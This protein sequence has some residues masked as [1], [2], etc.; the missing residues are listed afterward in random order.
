MVE[1][2]I[3]SQ[4]GPARGACRP[5][6]LR[7]GGRTWR[8]DAWEGNGRLWGPPRAYLLWRPVGRDVA[9]R[10][11]FIRGHG[12]ASELGHRATGGDARCPELGGPAS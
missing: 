8:R 7:T 11:L 5:G 3:G 12:D 6:T 4:V 1:K 2:R 9:G 10:F